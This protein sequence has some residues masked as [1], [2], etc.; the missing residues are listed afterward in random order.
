MEIYRRLAELVKYPLQ[1]GQG[2]VARFQCS[3]EA[4]ATVIYALIPIIMQQGDLHV[5]D[6]FEAFR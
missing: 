4:R 1:D 2:V 6:V 3:I 5:L